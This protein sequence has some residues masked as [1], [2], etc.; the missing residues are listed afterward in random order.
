MKK[1]LSV[2]AFLLTAFAVMAQK[3]ASGV[4]SLSD[5]GEPEPGVT[6]VVTGTTSGTITDFDG[7]FQLT[8][9]EGKT[10][11][12]SYTGYKKVTLQPGS[13]MNVV[14]EPD[15]MVLEE[16]VAVGYG[17]MKKSDVTGSLSSVKADQLQR[18]P[19]SGVDQA[20]QGK[21]AG[22]T[23]NA[24]SGQP[25]QGATIRIRGVG[26]VNSDASPIYVVDGVI[27]SDIAF[28]SPN[29][30][31][32]MEV[33]KDASSTA[34]Y[35]AQAANGVILI[36]TKSGSSEKAANISFSTYVGIQNRWK[37]LDLMSAQEQAMMYSLMGGKAKLLDA[38]LVQEDFN[39]WWKLKN[40]PS[41]ANLFYPKNFDF[42]SQETDWQD[43]VFHKNAVI[44]NY[45]LTISGGSDKGSYMLSADYF[46]QDGTIMGSNYDRLTIRLNSDFQARKWLKIGE[47][48]SYST[49]QGRN[50]MNNSAS[51]GASVIS[52]ALAMGQWDPTHYP[53]GSVNKN[54]EDISGN[55]SAGSLFTNVTNPFSMVYN[56]EPSSK[57]ER[58]VGDL[59]VD[60][61]PVKGLSIRPSLS[62]DLKNTRDRNFKYGPYSY[63]TY[64][65]SATDYLST[66]M[67][68]YCT[69]I[70][71][72]VINYS[73]TFNGKHFLSVMVGESMLQ[74]SNY[75][76]GSAGHGILNNTD[77][78]N[79]YLSNTLNVPGDVNQSR[80]TSDGVGRNRLLS[81]FGRAHYTFDE[82]YMITVN[83]RA[84]ASSK[85]KKSNHGVWGYFPSTALAWRI[86]K[87]SFLRDAENLDNLKLRLGWG[88]I[89]NERVGENSFTQTITSAGMYFVGYALGETVAGKQSAMPG[90]A[91][92]TLANEDGKWE[93]SEQWNVGL[94]FGAFNGM[95]YGSLDGYV[96]D[97][98]DAIL[99]VRAP[100]HV[101]NLYQPNKNVG[102][103]RNLGLELTLGHDNTVGDFR[104]GISAN[105]SLNK[106]EL[107]SLNGGSVVYG[108]KTKCDEGLPVWSF[109]G[110]K[111]E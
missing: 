96:K 8:V 45:H 103:I 4:V 80:S 14:L 107:K 41:G 19:A 1:S 81:F 55:P 56:S 75:S 78:K 86:N 92:N 9:P 36:T 23:V 7:N 89:G 83:F 25:G 16:V 90:S 12:I 24:S 40:N 43:E 15:D 72:N 54:G 29:D 85:F 100:G 62:M 91:V 106:N 71:D 20:L 63:S 108:D 58:W 18:T 77:P 11:E 30:I 3:Q 98:K 26:T 6:V 44:Q 28:L 95:L 33:M 21:A 111:Y 49:S 88:Q 84:D 13:G 50:A 35:G 10:I 60:I 31:A 94:D 102:I 69:L 109:W 76:L 99:S 53:E 5:T 22:V 68:R 39:K 65:A 48:L 2:L 64:D 51:A 32:S 52:A 66:S 17:T 79:W 74:Y 97:T 110:L 42:A 38:L 34:I 67:G 61:T 93:T 87:E 37:K 27:T 105:L 104:Y 57:T 70:N 59:F 47:N 82:R 73:N 46:S 101:G